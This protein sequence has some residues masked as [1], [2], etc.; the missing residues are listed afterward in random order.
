MEKKVKSK[1]YLVLRLEDMQK[2]LPEEEYKELYDEIQEV[3]HRIRCARI[4]DQKIREPE[5]TVIS[6][7][8]PYAREV[9]TLIE[10][11][12]EELWLNENPIQINEKRYF[13]TSIGVDLMYGSPYEVHWAGDNRMTG[14]FIGFE[15][16]SGIISFKSLQDSSEGISIASKYITD[17][18]PLKEET[19]N[20]AREDTEGA[21]CVG[22][23]QEVEE[24]PCAKPTEE[25]EASAEKVEALRIH[26]ETIL[27]VGDSYRVV[28]NN[29]KEFV[30]E[31]I[32]TRK[33]GTSLE[34]RLHNNHAVGILIDVIDVIDPLIG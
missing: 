16:E 19:L 18:I 21:V 29:G 22:T 31:L 17:I 5:Y 4:A 3:Q 10:L 25:L 32:G 33:N 26:G 8:E 23:N 9:K 28:H 27:V 15:S 24:I 30:G 14:R 20:D 13:K 11:R 2:Y 34:F 1:N 12:E 7:E 6:S